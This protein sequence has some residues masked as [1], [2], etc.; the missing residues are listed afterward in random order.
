MGRARARNTKPRKVVIFR[1][2]WVVA[3]GRFG[4]PTS[5]SFEFRVE[6]AYVAAKL[7]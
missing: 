5:R 3:G 7:K 1:G 2:F 6:V 4:R